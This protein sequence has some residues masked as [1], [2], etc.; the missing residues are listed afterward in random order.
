MFRGGRGGGRAG[1]AGRI[2]AKDFEIEADLE[3]EITAYQNEIGDGDDEWI[4]TLYPEMKVYLAP[5]PTDRE[6]KLVGYFR[7]HRNA[8]RNGP[9][10]MDGPTSGKRNAAEFNAF[11]DVPSYANKRIRRTGGMP[12][13]KKLPIV[14]ELLPREL[15][16][17]ISDGE[18]KEDGEAPKKNLNFL[19]KK[20][21][22]KLAQFDDDV[23]ETADKDD[24][25]EL[26]ENEGGGE[27]DVEELRDDDFSEDDDD[28][29]NDYNAEQYFDNGDDIDDEG[30]G[31]GGGEDAC[32]PPPAVT[33]SMSV[34]EPEDEAP[35]EDDELPS[36]D[37]AEL[38]DEITPVDESEYTGWYSSLQ[39]KHS[40]QNPFSA[41]DRASA[42]ADYLLR[43]RLE[44][45]G[46][47]KMK[48][49]GG[50][51]TG[52]KILKAQMLERSLKRDRVS[53]ATAGLSAIAV[54]RAPNRRKP[55]VPSRMPRG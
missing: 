4:K 34:A 35:V 12:N 20:R 51:Y 38:D 32:A 6:K 26:N 39:W 30:D 31:D 45:E 11:E 14:K 49:L 36:F 9:F 7:Q 44:L 24:D 10:F 17:V 15:W 46:K 28:L 52:N 18:E 22:D 2:G 33:G 41:R 8:M 50:A 25:D 55:Q 48:P 3:D 54:N 40:G 27:D 21:L 47:H 5:P 42:A 23:D 1:G 13:L 53:A 37:D 29:G 16:D 43:R 19:K